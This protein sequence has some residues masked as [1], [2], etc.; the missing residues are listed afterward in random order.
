MY[1][2][3]LVAGCLL[4]STALFASVFG[5]IRAIVHDPHHRPVANAEVILQSTTSGWTSKA[6]T[7]DAGVVQFTSVPIGTYTLQV[8]AMGFSASAANVTSISDRVQEVHVP[9]EL[10][11]I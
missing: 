6:T 3:S 1:R 7:N 5:T 10:P 8:R 2:R 9:L 4:L 11:S